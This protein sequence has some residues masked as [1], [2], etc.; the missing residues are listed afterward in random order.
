M[1][2]RPLGCVIATEGP[3]VCVAFVVDCYT[4]KPVQTILV[5]HHGSHLE[6]IRGVTATSARALLSAGDPSAPTEHPWNT[7]LA[8]EYTKVVKRTSDAKIRTAH[9]EVGGTIAHDPRTGFTACAFPPVD[10]SPENRKRLPGQVSGVERPKPEPA[11][12]VPGGRWIVLNGE[13][14]MSTGKASA[15]AAHVRTLMAL[16]GLP[17]GDTEP[18]ILWASAALFQ[19]LSGDPRTL[20]L[21]R[22]NGLTEV[23]RGSATALLVDAS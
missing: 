5:T 3:G 1:R 23:P 6:T 16:Q 20:L 7:W 14:G 9:A 13:L 11:A 18:D 4:M 21:S 8:G 15:Q 12:E 17:Q 10:D 2:P 19:A 22:D